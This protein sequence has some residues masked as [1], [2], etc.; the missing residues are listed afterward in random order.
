MEDH[1]AEI[2]ILEYNMRPFKKA[3]CLLEK[4]R[5]QNLC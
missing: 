5:D 4:K 3:L 2:K 1:L